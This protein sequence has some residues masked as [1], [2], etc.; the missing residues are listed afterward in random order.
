[1][2]VFP[3]TQHL[4]GDEPNEGRVIV[5]ISAPQAARILHEPVQ[6]LE[7][8]T[9]NPCGAIAYASSVVVEGS[10]NAEHE[11]GFKQG[12]ITGHEELLTRAADADPNDVGLQH[13]YSS[14]ELLL[15]KAIQIAKGWRIRAYD[16]GR[17]ELLLVCL[18]RNL[19]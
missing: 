19:G 5:Q 15:L 11:L 10:A 17:R 7:A 6:P 4:Q 12:K 16:S 18:T 13:G 1:M 3:Q 9:L 8:G 2:W 14:D